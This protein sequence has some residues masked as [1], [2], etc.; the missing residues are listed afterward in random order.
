M[1]EGETKGA[2]V[3][4][5]TKGYRERGGEQN[6]GQR[7][8]LTLSHLIFS[9][10]GCVSPTDF[11]VEYKTAHSFPPAKA[12]DR[13]RGGEESSKSNSSRSLLTRRLGGAADVKW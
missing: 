4:K 8:T 7:V 1:K 12:R 13:R 3:N 2:S 10:K 5:I 9:F 11:H 6:Q